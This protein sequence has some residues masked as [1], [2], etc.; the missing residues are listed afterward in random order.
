MRIQDI[1]STE[2]KAVAPGASVA[3]ARDL[4]TTTDL[5]ELIGRGVERPIERSTRWTLR[6]R[7]V[8]EAGA[9]ARHGRAS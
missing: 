2:I 6:S 9:S 3:A 7:G 1:M 8:R 5:L 4:M